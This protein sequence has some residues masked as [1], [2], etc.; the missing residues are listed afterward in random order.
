MNINK[1]RLGVA[2]A[3]ATMIAVGLLPGIAL[4]HLQ[5]AN[6]VD[7]STNPA[8]IRY[9]DGTGYDG[10]RIWSIDTWNSVGS[11][12]I[13]PDNSSTVA[14]LEFQTDASDVGLCGKYIP[15]ATVADDIKYYK[16]QWINY[17]DSQRKA[18]AV[19]E[20]GHALSLAHNSDD[21]T[22]AMDPCPV[23]VAGA[24]TLTT[25]PR[26]HDQYDYHYKWGN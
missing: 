13:A 15:Y 9:L 16:P 21:L 6:S 3:T 5:F 10:A 4:A 12:N 1:R 26:A 19:H 7:T 8:E 14:D 20:L 24:Q 17:T 2:A 22:Q 25:V 11:I 18:C 23:C